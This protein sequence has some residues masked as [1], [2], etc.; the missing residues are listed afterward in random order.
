MA[1][2][3]E[4]VF[5][6]ALR[7][8][9]VGEELDWA[10]GEPAE[11]IKQALTDRF[12][13]AGK[14]PVPRIVARYIGDCKESVT[15]PDLREALWPDGAHYSYLENAFLEDWIANHPETFAEA[16]NHGWYAEEDAE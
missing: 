9:P 4:D 8:V 15:E 5:N 7:Y 3:Q 1:E 11:N 6:D 2:T 16:W 10:T 12:A 14:V 13:A